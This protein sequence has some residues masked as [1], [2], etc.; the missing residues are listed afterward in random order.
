MNLRIAKKILAHQN[1]N[2]NKD[3]VR[4]Q[5]DFYGNYTGQQKLL[6]AHRIFRY[7]S[8]YGKGKLA[9]DALHLKPPESFQPDD[10]MD[11][12]FE[13][14]IG[15]YGRGETLIINTKEFTPPPSDQSKPVYRKDGQIHNFNAI[16]WPGMENIKYK[17]IVRT[18][19]TSDEDTKEEY[20]MEVLEYKTEYTNPNPNKKD[21]KLITFKRYQARDNNTRSVPH[22]HV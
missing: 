13:R 11:L 7:A 22:R 3:L 1:N 8:K 6:A 17:P 18:V 14:L 19:K 4:K 5:P 16:P 2:Y 9:L 21:R 15:Q 12:K 20:E 10:Q